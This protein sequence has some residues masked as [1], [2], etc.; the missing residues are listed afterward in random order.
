MNYESIKQ[1]LLDRLRDGQIEEGDEALLEQF[2]V[3]DPKFREELIFW[4]LL[5]IAAAVDERK[6]KN[7]KIAQFEAALPQH[8]SDKV[9]MNPSLSAARKPIEKTFFQR[10]SKWLRAAI[11]MVLAGAMVFFWKWYQG[12]DGKKIYA[13]FAAPIPND[14]APVVRSLVNKD[15]NSDSRTLQMLGARLLSEQ[16]S[17]NAL[18]SIQLLQLSATLRAAW[19][20]YDREEWTMAGLAV[21]N[22]CSATVPSAEACFLQLEAAMKQDPAKVYPENWI[23]FL[24]Q[25]PNHPRTV[26]AEWNFILSL[27]FHQPVERKEWNKPLPIDRSA[28]QL[29]EQLASEPSAVQPAA[30]RLREELKIF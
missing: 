19:E 30:A 6:R 28:A 9:E 12:P 20:Q 3:E 2:A 11:W 1:Q 21:Q 16:P 4:K 18:D 13:E 17:L 8:R 23:D 14:F 29:L 7:K 15:S 26:Y 24:L 10:N 27:I 5:P 25:Y 22:W